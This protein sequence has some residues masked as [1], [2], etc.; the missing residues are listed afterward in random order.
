MS[1]LS[2][3]GIWVGAT[4]VETSRTQRQMRLPSVDSNPITRPD[5]ENRMSN[6][7]LPPVFAVGGDRRYQ[8]GGWPGGGV[9]CREMWRP[10]SLGNWGV[11]SPG[12][13]RACR[14]M[15]YLSVGG[16]G[17]GYTTVPLTTGYGPPISR[18]SVILYAGCSGKVA[19]GSGTILRM[20]RTLCSGGV[21]PKVSYAS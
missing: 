12:S 4:S 20:R 17:G 13:G 14:K 9:G 19:S 1:V 16:Y 7:E 11:G 18:S 15:R 2:P 21:V 10:M 6:G 3:G 8:V 5:G